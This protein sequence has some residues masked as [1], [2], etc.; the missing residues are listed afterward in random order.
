MNLVVDAAR[1]LEIAQR[2]THI[3]SWEWELDSGKVEWSDELY[4]IY[5]LEPRARPI[6]LELF[7]SC[8]HPG[9]RERI[10]KEVAA[11]I[12]RGGR[13]GW[14]ERIVR[15]DGSI[16]E[17]DTIGEARRDDSGRVVALFGTCRDVTE[18]RERTEQVRLYADIVHSV[19]IG[20]SVWAADPP[21]T[22][23]RLVAYNPA[24]ERMERRPLAPFLG[25]SVPDIAPYAAGGHVEAM[26]DRVA[27]DRSVLEMHV[28]RSR[29]PQNPTRAISAK[30]FPLPG[31]R[32]GLAVEDVTVATIERRLQLAEHR[33]LE[34]VA[35]GA[36]LGE[37]LTAIVE[38]VEEHS[39]P[40]LGSVLLLDPDGVHVRDAAGPRLPDV[41]RRGIDG[42][43]VGPNVGSCGTAVHDKRTVI[44]SDI[45]TDPLWKDFRELALGSGLRAC[46]S[47]PIFATDHRV[48]G[49]F[50][51]YYREPRAPDEHGLAIMERAARLAGIAIERK[52][53]EEQLRDLT[54]HI[55]SALEDERT[56]IAREIH[57]E[58]GQS[59]T[60][61]KM[62]IA[63]IARRAS[64]GA[65]AL[66]RDT[67]LDKLRTM[68]SLADEVIGQIRRISAELRPGVLDDLGL[69]AAIEW[70]AQEFEARTGLRCTLEAA[71][72]DGGIERSVSTAVFRVF[73][74]ALTNVVR[75]AQASGVAVRVDVRGDT[76]S[77]EVTDDG[78]GIS[79][80]SA[81]NPK[82]L[83][84]LGMRER[85]R[86]LGGTASIGPAEP[87]GTRVALTMPL[88]RDGGERAGSR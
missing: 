30:A 9:D 23:P 41:Y 88:R 36:P 35:R 52:Q 80:D 61:L 56:G 69:V 22:P 81:R 79:P 18:E 21:G 53:L 28:E 38:A 8:L 57:D 27:R 13:F 29:D 48:L 77:L 63:W 2:I 33:A 34:M 64:E 54:G 40:V 70:Q 10:R 31:G 71:G 73:Q 72:S 47:V 84:L 14:P 1:Q 16:R 32:V 24:S 11:A 59:L 6:T 7:L 66:P 46:W 78:V 62:D 60:A 83:G 55:E 65:E 37:T 74:E 17:L 15:P 12:E 68:S 42:L 39:P 45:A 50:G 3:G 49:T 87:G 44:V 25:K 58:L 5:G 51:M 86:R 85:A 75:H 43:A 20:L 4:R 19:Q 82:S 76:L 67:L 26:L